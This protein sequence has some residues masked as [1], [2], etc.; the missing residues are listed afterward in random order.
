[1][2]QARKQQT[3]RALLDGALGLLEDQSL[4]S[5]GLRE[6]T[7][8]AGVTPT[9]FYRHF[10][11]M[12]DLGVALVDESLAS[13]HTMIRVTLAEQVEDGELIDATVEIIAR[14]VRDH[15]PHVRFLARERHGGVQAVRQAIDTE[16]GRF[17]DEVAAA[18]GKQ[19]AGAGWSSGELRML[20]RLYVD[21]MV[22]TAAALV[23]AA[24]DQPDEE[25][26]IAATARDQLR[27]ISVGR[28]HWHDQ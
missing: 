7:R 13:L 5:L 14:H 12:A 20:A 4:S 21:H 2:R 8:A 11:D 15:R 24:P 10:R 1:M 28:R 3:R 17:T 26:R 25:R 18:L 9:A 23:D 16:F 19:P 22:T 27:L 6:V